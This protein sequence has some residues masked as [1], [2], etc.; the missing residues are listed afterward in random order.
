[1]PAMPPITSPRRIAI[2]GGGIAG[3]AAANRI[4]ELDPSCGVVLFEASGRLGGAMW[5]EHR[6][7]FIVE[8]GADSFITNVPWGIDLCRRLGLADDLI[9]TSE[10]GRQ[11]FVV[12]RGRLC[13][14]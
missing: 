7:G 6:D 8:Q 9:G 12:R 11:T 1:P 4:R 5:T 14:I 2:I 13:P 10:Q 3:L